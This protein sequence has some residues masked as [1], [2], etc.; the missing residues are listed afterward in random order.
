MNLIKKFFAGMESAIEEGMSPANH[1]PA[2][3][4]DL[5]DQDHE[6]QCLMRRRLIESRL[7]M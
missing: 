3:P 6:R 2:V 1:P 5:A 7:P 4:V